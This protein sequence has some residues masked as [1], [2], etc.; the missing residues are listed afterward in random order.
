[1]KRFEIGQ[2]VICVDPPYGGVRLNGSLTIAKRICI[3]QSDLVSIA[4]LNPVNC[5]WVHRFKAA[6]M[7]LDPRI[8]TSNVCDLVRSI[9]ANNN[10]QILPILADALEEAGFDDEA[11]LFHLRYGEGVDD[12]AGNSHYRDNFCFVVDMLMEAITNGSCRQEVS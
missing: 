11:T 3:G 5:Y 9:F 7:D 6:P 10:W 2:K 4:E 8:L 1:M 12:K